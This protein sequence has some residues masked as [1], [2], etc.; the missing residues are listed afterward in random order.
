MI[1]ESAMGGE[2]YQYLK[3]H[4]KFNEKIARHIIL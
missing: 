3:L 1:M 4:E 2:L